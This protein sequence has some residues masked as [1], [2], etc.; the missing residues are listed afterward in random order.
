MSLWGS[1]WK[2]SLDK[3]FEEFSFS[4]SFD[5]R[6]WEEDLLGTCAHLLTLRKIG[7]IQEEEW[8]ILKE[9][10]IELRRRILD[11]L[12]IIQG[13]EDIHTFIE[14]NLTK[15]IGNLGKKIHTGRSRND[16][17]VLDLRLYLRKESCEIA[18]LLISLMTELLTLSNLYID[19]PIP[20][21]T[22]LQHAQPVTLG[23][24]FLA[25]YEMFQR[26]LERLEDCYKRIDVLPLGCGALAG[27]SIPLDREYTAKILGFSRIAE[28]SL[29]A[30]SDRDFV[31][32]FLFF[33]ATTFLHLS[34]FSEEITL[35]ATKEFSFIELPESYSTGSSMMPH[36][37]NP[38]LAEHTRGKTGRVLGDFLKV[39][40][41][42]KGLPLSY[43]GDLQEDKEPVFDALDQLKLTLKVW[44]RFLP[45]LR[46]KKERMYELA[47]NSFLFSTD[48]AE[49]L[50]MRGV[51]FR[52]AHKIVGEVVRYCEERGKNF[53]DLILEEWQRFSPLFTEEIFDMLSPE[54]SIY[55]KKTLGSP[56]PLLNKRLIDNKFDFIQKQKFLWSEKKGS[57][58]TLEKLLKL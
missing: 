13:T 6:L 16:Q 44:I 26:D 9:G 19:T 17:V 11:N 33:I 52:E 36:K 8:K 42:L 24:Y 55:S 46:F 37:R 56:S 43:N 45:K 35:W 34:R 21:Y 25:Y 57:L 15:I 20:G 10:I 50:V 22:H 30:V 2:Q 39:M 23:H 3:T 49:Y 29:D 51:P 40:I 31:I 41:V 4:L 32:E 47:K 7:I 28:N 5:K 54:K 1:R 12:E 38:D 18:D 14:E 27:S 58:P 53:E 48:I